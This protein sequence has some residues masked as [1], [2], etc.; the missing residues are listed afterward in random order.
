MPRFRARAEF[1]R[2]T[3][4]APW[5]LAGVSIAGRFLPARDGVEQ[6]RGRLPEP[7]LVAWL[8]LPE[9][10]LAGDVDGALAAALQVARAR[11]PRTDID[12]VPFPGGTAE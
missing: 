3:R 12:A 2:W 4:A 8:D 1:R 9:P 5:V 10:V 7:G 6:V 11:W